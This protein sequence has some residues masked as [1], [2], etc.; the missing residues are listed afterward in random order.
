MLQIAWHECLPR[1]TNALS[2]K[3]AIFADLW[4]GSKL[5]AG[6]VVTHFEVPRA[7]RPRKGTAKMAVAHQNES[8]PPVLGRKTPFNPSKGSSPAEEFKPLGSDEGKNLTYCK[9][10]ARCP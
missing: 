3:P 4:H 2:F 1:L 10:F 8:L 7:S 9:Y 6:S 5:T